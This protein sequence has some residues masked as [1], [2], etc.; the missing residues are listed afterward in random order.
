MG[1]M[2][3]DDPE[4][5]AAVPRFQVSDVQAFTFH[6]STDMYTAVLQYQIVWHPHRILYALTQTILMLSWLRAALTAPHSVILTA[7]LSHK[8]GTSCMNPKTILTTAVPVKVMTAR[9]ATWKMRRVKSHPPALGKNT[10]TMLATL[11]KYLNG[12]TFV[13]LQQIVYLRNGER[14]LGKLRWHRRRAMPP[15]ISDTIAGGRWH[16][17]CLLVGRTGFVAAHA[18]RPIFFANDFREVLNRTSLPTFI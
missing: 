9:R 13:P 16:R 17:L 15:K 1:Y 7:N 3:E 10:R 12:K 5:R 6:M 14:W 4:S 8:D 2:P 18:E 11:K